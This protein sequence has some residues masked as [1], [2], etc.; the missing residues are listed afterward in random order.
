MATFHI[1]MQGL[2]PSIVLIMCWPKFN[3]GPITASGLQWFAIAGFHNYKE[4]MMAIVVILAER[5][6]HLEVNWVTVEKR[7]V[8]VSEGADRKMIFRCRQ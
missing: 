3:S 4:G 7:S 5:D 1:V 2:Y 8:S 6:D